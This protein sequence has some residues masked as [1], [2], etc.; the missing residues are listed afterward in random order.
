[1]LADSSIVFMVW[2]CEYLEGYSVIPFT[3][4]VKEEGKTKRTEY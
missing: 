1:M 3:P 2:A 4:S